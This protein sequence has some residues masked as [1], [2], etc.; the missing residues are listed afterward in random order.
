M[1]ECDPGQT[2]I[3]SDTIRPKREIIGLINELERDHQPIE[4]DRGLA[5]AELPRSSIW[6]GRDRA[7]KST[8][9]WA[10]G[11]MGEG[12]KRSQAS[13]ARRP[14]RRPV[15]ATL[16]LAAMTSACAAAVYAQAPS[17]QAPKSAE[18]AEK[19]LESEKGALA[20]KQARRRELQENI[21]GIATERQEI[22]ARLRDTAALVQKSEDQMTA[23]E[24]RLTGFE[25]REQEL[26]ASLSKENDKISGI[27][28]ALQRMGRNPPPVMITRREDALEMV[29]S[30]MLLGIAFP[31][32]RDEAKVLSA[33]LG[34]LMAVKDNIR[35]E[36]DNLRAETERL[37]TTQTRLA[38]LLESK[39]QSL[40]ERQAELAQVRAATTEIA[41]NVTDLGELIAKL[42]RQVT[43]AP[44][45]TGPEPTGTAREGEPQGA[46]EDVVAMLPP[47]PQTGSEAAPEATGAI[48]RETAAETSPAAV[49]APPGEAVAMITPPPGR[50]SPPSIVEMAPTTA[51]LGGAGKHELIAPAIPFQ[52][53]KGKL[54]LPARG[55]RAL[56]FGAK[57]QYGGTSKG[58]VIE[59][60]FGARVT[61]P[62]DGWVV[63]AGEF[64]SYGQLLIINAGGGYHVLIA[65]LSQMDVGPGQFVLA[66]EPIGTMSGA[67]RTAQL[68]AGNTGMGQ[69]PQS[70]APVLY[71][72]FRKDGDPVDSAP[73]W[74]P[75]QKVQE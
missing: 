46:G 55:R 17:T 2:V 22:T 53:A 7:L 73:W 68:T 44:P 1:G 51:S 66:A 41:K 48:A 74:A 32:L 62:C 16:L 29:R 19:K 9:K 56:G 24:A 31:G 49:P 40:S 6:I 34:E 63:Y 10:S 42:S 65:G 70:S 5:C 12:V 26:R 15:A 69:P 67:P 52:A 21:E 38:S 23:I 36:A 45:M 43:T 4:S 72:E 27:L 37:A 20:A 50:E 28:S 33:K 57:T 58:I 30:A 60:R 47:A 75:T 14:R 39:K 64:R 54:P 11:R 3:A 59:T 71:V 8:Q 13:K 25:A 61:A 35:R 18:E